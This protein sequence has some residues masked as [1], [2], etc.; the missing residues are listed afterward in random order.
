MARNPEELKRLAE[1]LATLTPQE[2][3]RVLTLVAGRTSTPGVPVAVPWEK[4][5]AIKGFVSLGGN[6]V[7]D[8]ER[9]YDG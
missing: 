8:C 6:A 1:E 4:L 7:K 5:H 9:L 3:A 2:R